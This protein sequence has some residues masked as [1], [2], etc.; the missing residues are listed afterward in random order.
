MATAATIALLQADNLSIESGC[1]VLDTDDQVIGEISADGSVVGS[2]DGIAGGEVERNCYAPVAGLARLTMPDEWD[3]P[4]VRF[5][6]YMTCTSS[7]YAEQ[8]LLG[9][10]VAP[11]PEIASL[12][13]TPCD[14]TLGCYDKTWLLNR[15]IG[16]TYFV[17]AGETY[18]NALAS[19]LSD[20]GVTGRSPLFDQTFMDE[21]LADPMEWPLDP[22]SPTT[23]LDAANHI[24]SAIGYRPLW[25][26]QYGRFRSE[27]WRDP[28][29]LG[30]DW[31]LDVSDP[32]TNIVSDAGDCRVLGLGAINYWRFWLKTITASPVEGTTQYTLDETGGGMKFPR[33]ESIEAASYS[34][35]VAEAARRISADRLRS[36]TL[37][38]TT[39]P[40]PNIG[41][42]WRIDV[43]GLPALG[44]V[45]CEVRSYTL[46]LDGSDMRITLEIIE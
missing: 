35:L 26:D 34:G 22:S 38:L 25:A 30:A 10:F 33:C 43:S 6:P 40:L 17:A 41:H 7:T 21:V 23:W 29:T 39:N 46:P 31:T 11:S 24:L 9:V 13:D 16:D 32:R 4:N 19:L 45:H 36:R 8:F 20:S 3:W 12:G 5:E 1:Y 37:V 42:R 14:F 44:P 27:P 2:S 18:L 15:P 28:A